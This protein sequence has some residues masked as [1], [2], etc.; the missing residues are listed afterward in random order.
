M[1]KQNWSS[2]LVAAFIGVGA[3]V[4]VALWFKVPDHTVDVFAFV[5]S[6]VGIGFTVAALVITLGILRQ[7][8]DFENML[9]TR[10]DEM[11]AAIQNR[12]ENGTVNALRNQY[13]TEFNQLKNRVESMVYSARRHTQSARYP[14]Q[15]HY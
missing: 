10:R 11:E 9:L 7:R 8:A 1:T 3:G 2:V 15:H 6:A 13:V 4:C 5:E 12:I 14:S